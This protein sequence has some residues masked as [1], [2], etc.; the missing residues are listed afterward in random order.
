MS[1]Q[2][3]TY[4]REI[5][6]WE[7][8]GVIQLG[9]RISRTA[10]EAVAQQKRWVPG[11]SDEQ[12]MLSSTHGDLYPGEGSA[13]V[14][15]LVPNDKAHAVG[16]SIAGRQEYLVLSSDLA[17]CVVDHVM[18][19]EGLITQALV[20]YTY[21]EFREIAAVS[22][23]DEERASWNDVEKA[24][25]QLS[26]F[27]ADSLGSDLLPLKG[28]DFQSVDWAAIVSECLEEL[29]VESGRDRTVGL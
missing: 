16:D 14:T 6:S 28:V 11:H 18:I 24:A 10:A 3:W 2:P 17:G 21:A 9:R 26:A 5:S 7:S 25:E 22:W 23:W 29:N 1:L 27:V 19:T 4:P 12:V 13:V 20:D 15:V 8:T